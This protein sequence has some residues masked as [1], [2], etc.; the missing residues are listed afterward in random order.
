MRLRF[1]VILIVLLSLASCE[2]L[3][4]LIP[5]GGAVDEDFEDGVIDSPLNCY[6]FGEASAE[7]AS[8]DGNSFLLIDIPETA[9]SDARGLFTYDN[10]N[11]SLTGSYTLE[12][13][14][15][16][17]SIDSEAYIVTKQIQA[18]FPGTSGE[19]DTKYLGF[20][21]YEGDLIADGLTERTGDISYQYY[22]DVP[23]PLNLNEWLHVRIEN[24]DD[25]ISIDETS[26]REE[27]IAKSSVCYIN[28]IEVSH[29]FWDDCPL[30]QNTFIEAAGGAIRF[31][32]D[33]YSITFE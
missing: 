17:E 5:G 14:L 19:E 15:W 18:Y 7:L 16:I 31:R 4:E 21:E 1:F 28:D 9:S 33:N 30:G 6:L 27:T 8:E 12:F 13:D 22:W 2:L 23:D 29:V 26:H 24:E 20:Y 3:L 11:P 32:I 25:G 10:M